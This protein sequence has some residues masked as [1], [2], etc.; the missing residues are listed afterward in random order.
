MKPII[1]AQEDENMDKQDKDDPIKSTRAKILP[2]YPGWP[3]AELPE[4]SRGLPQI[5]VPY[6]EDE[7]KDL[8]DCPTTPYSPF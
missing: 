8:Y 5:G 3:P 7:K 6:S 1:Q 4:H 2:M